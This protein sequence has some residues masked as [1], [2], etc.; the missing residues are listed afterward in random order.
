MSLID[1]MLQYLAEKVSL[2]PEITTQDGWRITK[3]SDGYVVLEKR[4]AFNELVGNGISAQTTSAG[5]YRVQGN[6]TF[7]FELQDIYSG[8]ADGSQ[9]GYIYGINFGE[10]LEDF[11]PINYMTIYAEA[12]KSF[13]SD[14]LKGYISIRITGRWK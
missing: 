4:K 2:K 1:S 12:V 9:T 5:F 10:K 13:E 6:V 7:P 8:T 3:H 14:D 11:L